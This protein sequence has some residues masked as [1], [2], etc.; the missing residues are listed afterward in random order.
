M[1]E[2]EQKKELKIIEDERPEEEKQ[3]SPSDQKNMFIFIVDR[4]GSMSGDPIMTTVEALK[5]FV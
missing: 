3:V 5:L 4:S 1:K 2:Q